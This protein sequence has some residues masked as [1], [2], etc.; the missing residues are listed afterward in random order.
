MEDLINQGFL[1]IEVIGPHMAEG[2]Y[3]LVGPDGEVILPQVW[4]NIIEP[5]WTVTMHIVANTRSTKGTRYAAPR[6]N[7]R[8]RGSEYFE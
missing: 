8:G 7:Q 4:E 6:H 2:H 5:D 3:D 1:R